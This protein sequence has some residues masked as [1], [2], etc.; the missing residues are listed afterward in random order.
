MVHIIR[1]NNKQKFPSLDTIVRLMDKSAEIAKKRD[2][3]SFLG[4]CLK[5]KG[6]F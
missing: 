3:Q 1:S 6:S 4:T 5:N 2:M